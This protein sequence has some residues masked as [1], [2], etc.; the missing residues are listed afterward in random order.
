[1]Y[2]AMP[3]IQESAEE[4]RGLMKAE[5]RPKAQQRLHA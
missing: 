3:S 1:M 2:Q 4:L 5:H